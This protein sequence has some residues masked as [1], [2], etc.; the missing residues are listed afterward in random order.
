M[1]YPYNLLYTHIRTHIWH[2]ANQLREQM[3]KPKTFSEFPAEVLRREWQK[4]LVDLAT[5]AETKRN[6]AKHQNDYIKLIVK[7]FKEIAWN[8]PRQAFDCLYIASMTDLK[9]PVYQRHFWYVG[10]KA[11]NK[12]RDFYLTT[13][14]D[15]LMSPDYEQEL[16]PGLSKYTSLPLTLDDKVDITQLRYDYQ[17]NIEIHQ[18]SFPD[19]LQQTNIN[20]LMTKGDEPMEFDEPQILKNITQ[21]GHRDF[22]LANWM[23]DYGT[24]KLGFEMW[25]NYIG[26]D[27]KIP[28]DYKQTIAN[29]TPKSPQSQRS[30]NPP[31][32]EKSATYKALQ[33]RQKSKRSLR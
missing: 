30:K 1:A 15:Q 12:T 6:S 27:L 8:V 10:C 13:G 25:Y 31:G 33:T 3:K 2:H 11:M 14:R 21:L 7:A 9:D 26:K 24:T 4:A 18:L 5:E 29:E 28:H 19:W 32:N 20:N 16:A 17:R 23:M 22:F